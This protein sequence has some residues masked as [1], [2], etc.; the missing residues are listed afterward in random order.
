MSTGNEK[1]GQGTDAPT[2]RHQPPDGSAALRR[3]ERWWD[4][5]DWW[6]DA[7]LAYARGLVDGYRLGRDDQAD[8]DDAVHRNAVRQLVGFV[9]QADRRAEADRGELAA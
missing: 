6:T 9:A 1:D 3:V 2:I 4:V 5:T 7:R 8:E